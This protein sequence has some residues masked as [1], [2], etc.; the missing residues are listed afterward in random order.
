MQNIKISRSLQQQM[1]KATEL[2]LPI[3]QRIQTLNS[4]DQ[5]KGRTGNLP[6][7]AHQFDGPIDIFKLG[8]G[9]K[10]FWFL[11]QLEGELFFYGRRKG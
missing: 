3:L 5:R 9:G 2:P 8:R 7:L 1:Q 4:F 6:G 10:L 11:T